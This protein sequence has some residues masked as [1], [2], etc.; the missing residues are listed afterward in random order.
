MRT[1]LLFVLTVISKVLWFIG[2]VLYGGC[3]LIEMALNEADAV[4]VILQRKL[5]RDQFRKRP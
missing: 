5:G 4:V 1:I 2:L 3:A